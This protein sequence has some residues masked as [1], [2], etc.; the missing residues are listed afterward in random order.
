MKKY[1]IIYADLEA[2]SLFSGI[3]GDTLAAEWAGFKTK[4]FVENNIYCQKILRKHWP[5]IP[6]WEDI[7]DFKAEKYRGIHLVYGGDPCQPNSLAGQRRGAEDD[8]YKWPEMLRV[9]HECK[10]TWIVSEN[11]TGRLSMD[12]YKVLSDL[13]SEGYGTSSFVIPACAV[14]ASHRRDRLYIIAYSNHSS[15]ARQRKNSRA[16]LQEPKSEGFGMGI[17]ATP[18]TIGKGLEKREEQEYLAQCSTTK[19]DNKSIANAN[20]GGKQQQ[21]GNIPESRGWYSYEG[22]NSN[23]IEVATA[24]CGV[25][26]GIPNRVARLKALGNAQVPQQIY[27]IFKTIADIEFGAM[28]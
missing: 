19:R 13:A 8:R 27:P 18:D 14:N 15:T 5:E 16:I 21:K 28:E 23:W 12:F 26:D 9:I 3:G 7:D 1:Q 20:S 6:I 2:I 22:W 4:V 11:P 25:D 17:T 10:P 24:L